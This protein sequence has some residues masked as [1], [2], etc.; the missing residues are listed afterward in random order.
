MYTIKDLLNVMI[1]AD[2]SDLFIS[3]GTYPMLKISGNILPLEKEKITP[4]I[5]KGLKENLLTKKQLKIFMEEY[6]LDFTYSLPGVGR[7]RVNFFRQRNSDA[8]VIRRILSNIQ[9]LED[10]NLPQILGDL[11]LNEI[12]LVLVVGATGSG[13]STTLAAMVDHRNSSISG[14]ILTLEDP[15]EFLHNHKKGIVN[16]REIGEDTKTFHA[17]L[18]SALREAPSML[19]IGEIRDQIT[20][21]AALGFSET[22]HLVLSTLHANNAYQ[23]IE[24]IMSF[25]ESS[26]HEMIKLQLSQNLRAVIAQRLVPTMDGKRIAALEILLAS[27]R[28]RDLIHKG[29]IEL[30]RHTIESSTVEGMQLF[31]QSLYKLFKEGI[32]DQETAIR[33]S[34]RPTDLKLEIRSKEEQIFTQKIE[35]SFEE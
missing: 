10:L 5:I 27:A 19:L 13:K 28:V 12:G 29:E 23:T 8:F 18:R 30:L 6:E 2:A 33:C 14:H 16:Q 22:G 24:R 25:Y 20:M 31:D 9:T 4:E 21:S 11:A 15:V 3:I 7:F 17:A 34:D 26:Q 35:L 1:E 32:I